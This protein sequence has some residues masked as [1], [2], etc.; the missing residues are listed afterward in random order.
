MLIF[1]AIQVVLSQIPNF[2]DIE[3]LSIVAAIMSFAYAFIG[4]GLA[5]TQV[6]GMML[7]C[8]LVSVCWIEIF[9]SQTLSHS[10]SRS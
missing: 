6:K 3:W 1:G 8:S 4:M 10:L 9:C 5:I 7:S 2:H